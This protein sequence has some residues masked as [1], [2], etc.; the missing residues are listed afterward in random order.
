METLELKNMKE[1]FNSKIDQIEER[2]Y[3]PKDRL[4]ERTQRRKRK[5]NEQD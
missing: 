2:I 5:R 3:E 1:G 4:L